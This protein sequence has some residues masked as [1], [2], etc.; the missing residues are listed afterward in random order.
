MNAWFYLF[1]A[2]ISEVVGTTF[3]KLSDGFTHT[4]YSIAC[5]VC[6]MVALY[7]LSLCVKHLDISVVYAIWSAVGIALISVIGVVFF[8]EQF[9]FSKLFFIALI[10]AGVIGLQLVSQTAK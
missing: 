7:M 9:T 3:L 8:H 1:F 2:I 6:F 4:F 5:L 10:A